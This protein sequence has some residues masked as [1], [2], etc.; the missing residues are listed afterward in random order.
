MNLMEPKV[1]RVG[2]ISD[3]S[4][5]YK[6]A[7]NDCGRTGGINMPATMPDTDPMLFAR[8]A[9]HRFLREGGCTHVPALDAYGNVMTPAERLTPHRTPGR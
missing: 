5:A 4:I 1:V 3:G 9:L 7:C 2:E 8:L 6:L